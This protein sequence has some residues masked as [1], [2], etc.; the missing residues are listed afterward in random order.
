MIDELKSKL[1]ELAERRKELQPKL[2]EINAKR[3]EDHQAVNKKYDHMVYDLEYNISRVEM[4][5][6]NDLIRSLRLCL[7]SMLKNLFH[8]FFGKLR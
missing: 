4:E 5:L 6:N 1:K 3:E 2:D 7:I 8:P